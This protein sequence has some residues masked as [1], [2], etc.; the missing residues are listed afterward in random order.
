[1]AANIKTIDI[2]L[3]ESVL[4][5]GCNSMTEYAMLFQHL[6]TV[7]PL[8]NTGKVVRHEVLIGS[9]EKGH[10]L[11]VDHFPVFREIKVFYYQSVT[12]RGFFVV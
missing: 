9:I 8:V 5:T 10:Y 11:K 4:K 12:Y 2:L 1:M 6:F 3:V 7:E